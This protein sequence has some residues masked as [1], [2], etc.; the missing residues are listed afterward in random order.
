MGGPQGGPQGQNK[1][2]QGRG[3]GAGG[4]GAGPGG[5]GGGGGAG[6]G[7]GG[8]GGGNAAGGL[9]E[10]GAGG[11]GPGL[12]AGIGG[13]GG[14][15]NADPNSPEGAVLAFLNAINSGDKDAAA[16][17]VSSKAVG[18]LAKLRKGE[19]DARGI[20]KFV[21]TY[22]KMTSAKK[23]PTRQKADETIVVLSPGQSG[24][25]EPKKGAPNPNKQVIVRNEDGGWKILKM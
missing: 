17:L 1:G 14:F 19:L 20:A 13:G 21:E 16:K 4:A 24:A 6:A 12:G 2:M 7:P 22:G 5:I 23:A 25:P 8:A 18:D 3:A 15:A 11:G 10:G 9:G